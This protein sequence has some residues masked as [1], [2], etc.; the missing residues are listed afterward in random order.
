MTLED[1][2]RPSASFFKYKI[3]RREM[4]E[5]SYCVWFCYEIFCLT[6]CLKFTRKEDWLVKSNSSLFCVCVC[7][8]VC[9]RASCVCVCEYV[10]VCARARIEIYLLPMSEICDVF[11][12]NLVRTLFGGGRF[13]VTTSH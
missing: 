3:H 2:V 6:I 4:L 9:V 1:Y 5:D 13:V 10:C 7:V 12:Q 8:P 11:S